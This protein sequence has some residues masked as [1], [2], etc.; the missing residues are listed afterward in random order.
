MQFERGSDGKL[1]PLP[2]PSVDTGMGLERTAAVM[3]GVHSNYEIDLF[4][5]IIHAAAA[6]AG[7]TDES[8][9]SLRVIADHILS[10]IHI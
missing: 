10:L 1:T 9:S 4:K 3:Q 8:L 6:L 5:Y 7:V 2:K